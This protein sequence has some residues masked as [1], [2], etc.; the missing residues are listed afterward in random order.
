MSKATYVW[1]ALTFLPRLAIVCLCAV[2]LL[3]GICFMS[4]YGGER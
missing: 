2:F 1:Y 3:A 4:C